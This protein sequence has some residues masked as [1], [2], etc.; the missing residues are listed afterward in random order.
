M[1]E[2]RTAY[3]GNLSEEVG[4]NVTIEV[5]GGDEGTGKLENEKKNDV[6]SLISDLSQ[7]RNEFYL[8][9]NNT[10]TQRSFR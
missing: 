9:N 8:L 1:A 6:R 3:K 4:T 10:T 2:M 5:M 7:N